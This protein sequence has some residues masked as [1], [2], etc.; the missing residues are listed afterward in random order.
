MMKP[1]SKLKSLDELKAVV[2]QIHTA[3][4]TVVFA[5][6]CFDLIHVGHVRYLQ[7]I[8]YSDDFLRDAIHVFDLSGPVDVY[9]SERRITHIPVEYRTGN[10]GT[11]HI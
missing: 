4:K 8:V 3:G 6:G 2:R 10:G 5:N 1:E 9:E 7:V 11:G